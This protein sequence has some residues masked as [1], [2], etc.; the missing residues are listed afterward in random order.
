MT[1]EMTAT[2]TRKALDPTR[3]GTCACC[4]KTFNVRK[5]GSLV[6]H[7]WKETGRRAGSYGNGWQWGECWGWGTRPLEE[8]DLSGLII[9][10]RM[11]ETL[12]RLE[13]ELVAHEKG[14]DVYAWTHTLQLSRNRWERIRQEIIEEFLSAQGVSTERIQRTFGK[15][16]RLQSCIDFNTD[17]PRGFEGTLVRAVNVD[18]DD[19]NPPQVTCEPLP[20]RYIY[21]P[22]VTLPSYEARRLEVVKSITTS[23]ANLKTQ[24][25]AVVAAIAHHKENPSWGIPHG[26]K[27]C[28]HMV[29]ET[30]KRKRIGCNWMKF[31]Y[32]VAHSTTNAGLVTC[33]R[34]L[35]AMSN[36]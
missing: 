19:T 12:V 2:Y 23:I 31:P 7:G 25:K 6:R 9:I 29:Y 3:R 16:G 14:A 20:D 32:E 28:V 18:A 22:H 17:I 24:R 8:T 15:Y 36:K 5:D 10:A 13:E 11:D 26:K 21:E 1:S 30:P 33:T 4:L 34:C 27:K 35:K